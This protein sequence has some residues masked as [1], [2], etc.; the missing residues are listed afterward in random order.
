MIK[1]TFRRKTQKVVGGKI[2]SD[3]KNACSDGEESHEE[4]ARI[5]FAT[6]KIKSKNKTIVRT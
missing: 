1:K 5:L 4:T 3:L 6:I 2:K